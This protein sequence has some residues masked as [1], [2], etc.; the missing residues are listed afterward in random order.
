MLAPGFTQAST[1]IQLRVERMTDRIFSD[2][3]EFAEFIEGRMPL[4]AGLARNKTACVEAVV[5]AF[6]PATSESAGAT[7]HRAIFRPARWVVKDSDLAVIE[8][9]GGI[10]EGTATGAALMATN[11]S[12]A[13]AAIPVV[14]V[15]LRHLA[16]VVHILW[17]RGARL[18][19][20]ELRILYALRDSSDGASTEMLFAMLKDDEQFSSVD[21]VQARVARLQQYPTQAGPLKLVWAGTDGR[22]R[23][24]DI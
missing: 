1:Q 22:W 23:L 15:L 3:R 2:R 20:E 13:V 6:T 10:V 18:S 17:T 11:S 4:R 8:S 12:L 24:N 7:E 9:F 5:V 19:P 16:K 21:E 14:A